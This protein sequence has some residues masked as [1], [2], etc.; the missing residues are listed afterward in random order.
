MGSVKP[1]GFGSVQGT[2]GSQDSQREKGT[3]ETIRNLQGRPV[4]VTKVRTGLTKLIY[5]FTLNALTRLAQVIEWVLPVDKK[6]TASSNK[7]SLSPTD[8]KVYDVPRFITDEHEKN[9]VQ[10][11][12]EFFEK[13]RGSFNIQRDSTSDNFDERYGLTKCIDELERRELKMPNE[14]KQEHIKMARD[15]IAEIKTEETNKNSPMAVFSLEMLHGLME[16][17]YFAYSEAQQKD[18]NPTAALAVAAA[19]SQASSQED[20]PLTP[21]PIAAAAIPAADTTQQQPQHQPTLPSSPSP[22]AAAKTDQLSSPLPPSSYEADSLPLDSDSLGGRPSTAA[23]SPS[24]KASAP[25]AI[26]SPKPK[27][28]LDTQIGELKD[29]LIS[30]TEKNRNKFNELITHGD[31]FNE[32]NAQQKS[33]LNR[34]NIKNNKLLSMKDKITRRKLNPDEK[35]ELIKELKKAIEFA[36]WYEKELIAALRL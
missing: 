25:A 7:P 18:P 12:T 10:K 6:Q 16:E 31:K 23:V 3:A 19:A 4:R 11:R 24:A 1:P 34:V 28:P 29:E 26:D 20:P 5:N 36:Q 30:L 15:R 22:R 9:D 17:L 32:L 27:D 33:V 14:I 35:Q 8:S 2:S 21:S 13:V